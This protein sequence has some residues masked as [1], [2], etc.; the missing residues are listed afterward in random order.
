MPLYDDLFSNVF[1]YG[2]AKIVKF[3]ETLSCQDR[4]KKLAGELVRPQALSDELSEFGM[5]GFS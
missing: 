5:L 2:C 3:I 4:L 1:L